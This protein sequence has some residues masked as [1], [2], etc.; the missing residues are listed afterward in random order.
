MNIKGKLLIAAMATA[1]A[2]GASAQISNV[3][4]TTSASQTLDGVTTNYVNPVPSPNYANGGP[5]GAGYSAS[6]AIASDSIFFQAGTMAAGRNNSATSKV[7][8]SFDVTGVSDTELTKVRSTIFESNFGFFVGNFSDFV[9][10]ETQE[11]VKGCSGVSL[12]SC[13]PT[14]FAPGFDGFVAP[15]D[16]S[17]P[18][19]LAST[20]FT[21]EVLQDGNL[22]R[23]VSGS[24][25]AVKQGS[26]VVFAKGLGFAELE[27]VLGNF[28]QFEGEGSEGK[29]YAFS[30][31]RT[32]FTADLLD[33]IG[34][35]ETST[36]SYRITTSS[37][38]FATPVGVPPS[39]NLI[40]AFSCF[41][42]PI[43]R[44]GTRG[45]VFTIPGFEASTCNEYSANSS[46]TPYA[47]K[48]PVINGDTIDFRAPVIPEPDTWAMLIVGFGLVGLS[49]RRSKKA[50]PSTTA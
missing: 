33:S 4:S 18:V 26:S 5:G 13:K 27:D 7:E 6:A 17:P 2:T 16:T 9:D 49:M 19:T 14:T 8:V 38:N 12:P 25:D 30:W 35:G 1:V 42:D 31:D 32:D 11:L 45:A 48:I 20:Q 15:G 44:G 22:L 40:V 43:G 21:F 36:I 28:V 10:P 34:F 47:I 46:V 3:G 37:S 23:S 41:A 24:I 39:S 29:I 50:V